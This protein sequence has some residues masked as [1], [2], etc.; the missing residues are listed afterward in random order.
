MIPTEHWKRRSKR[1]QQLGLKGGLEREKRELEKTKKNYVLKV[2]A[3]TESG[4]S[5]NQ[6]HDWVFGFII[7]HSL[8][9]TQETI[10]E[11]DILEK[12][13][14]GIPLDNHFQSK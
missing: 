11:T 14:L 7:D 12:A 13:A 3:Y 2:N 6:I 1:I 10:D 8:K 5:I 9:E 4:G